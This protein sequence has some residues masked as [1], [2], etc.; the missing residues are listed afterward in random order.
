M[1]GTLIESSENSGVGGGISTVPS[2]FWVG[3][4]ATRA[5][6]RAVLSFDTRGLPNTAAVTS[7]R[8]RI[9]LSNMTS[10]DPFSFLGRLLVDVGVPQFGQRPQLERSDFQAAATRTGAAAFNPVPS[11][12][13]YTAALP[14]ARL[15]LIDRTGW[16]QFRLRFALD[17]NNDAVDNFA[18]F[19]SGDAP[20]VSDRPI[21]IVQYYVP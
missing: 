19:F 21:L 9:K 5:Q 2:R 12:G 4:L 10:P 17:D 15:G 7:A 1:D 8:I 6:M 3:D 20:T 11:A 18:A 13:W 14:P 16:T